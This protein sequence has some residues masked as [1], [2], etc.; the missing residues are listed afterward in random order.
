MV[1]GITNV[2]GGII[3]VVGGIITVVGGIIIVVGESSQFPFSSSKVNP[4]LQ[5]KHF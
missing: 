3:S 2:V 5:D 1:G 4:P